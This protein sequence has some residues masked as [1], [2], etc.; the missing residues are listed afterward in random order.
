MIKIEYKDYVLEYNRN[1]IK[2]LE[3]RGFNFTK[4]Q[5]TVVTNMELLFWGA[6]LK[7]HNKIKLEKANEILDEMQAEGYD[8]SELLEVL[9]EMI[10]EAIPFVQKG[11]GKKKF[12][13]IR[14]K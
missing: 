6:F 10:Q 13:I 1:S 2:Q 8:L 9:M 5:E 3:A 14:S 11:K 7:N 4:M 12:S